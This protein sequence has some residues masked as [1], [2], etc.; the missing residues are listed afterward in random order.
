MFARLLILVSS[1]SL[2]YSAYL[3]WLAR[4]TVLHSKK[5]PESTYGSPVPS[6]VII[7]VLASFL[8]LTIGILASAPELKGVTWAS[9]MSKRTI[10]QEVSLASFSGVRHRGGVLFREELDEDEE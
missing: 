4:A 5:A 1:I 7:Q 2:L 9:E 3:A 6:P 8:F 10:D